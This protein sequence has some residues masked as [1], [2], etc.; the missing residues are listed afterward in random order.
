MRC[1]AFKDVV[2]AFIKTIDKPFSCQTL[3]TFDTWDRA[4]VTEATCPEST[5]GDIFEYI[6]KVAVAALCAAVLHFLVLKITQ[7]CR[8]LEKE[9]RGTKIVSSSATLH[10]CI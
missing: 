1:R 2:A 8:N 7:E 3:K 4:G 6:G 5:V 10:C 9:N